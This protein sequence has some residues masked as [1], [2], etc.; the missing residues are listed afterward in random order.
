M[1]CKFCNGGM[2]EVENNAITGH[3]EHVCSRCGSTATLPGYNCDEYEW[4]EN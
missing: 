2:L 3:E 1:I 4:E